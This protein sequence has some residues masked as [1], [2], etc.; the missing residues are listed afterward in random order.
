MNRWIPILVLSLAAA[1]AA[2]AGEIEPA[3]DRQLELL[4]PDGTATALVLLEQQAPVEELSRDLTR[5]GAS[6]AERHETIVR[7]LRD[8]AAMQD[9]LI[10]HLDDGLRS[11]AVEGY[12]SYWIVN[13]V[14][15]RAT[16]AFLRDLALRS[17]VASVGTNPVAEL[18]EPV[19]M[20]DTFGAPRGIG[21][22]RGQQA[23]R[24]DSV[25]YQL[26]I[27]GRGRVLAN[28]DTGVD[29]THPA[30][31]A[32]WRGAN[33]HPYH[34]CWLDVIGDGDT[35]FPEDT[36]SHGTHVMGTITGLG[37]ETGDT[38]GVAWGAQWIAC[39]AIGQGAND[40]FDSDIITA[41]Q[42]LADPDGD[43]ATVDDVPDVVQ[44]SWRVNEDFPGYEDCDPRWWDAIDHCEAGGCVVI[45]SAG[46][47]GPAPMTIGSPPDRTTTPL[48]CF[49]V[50]AVDATNYDWPY[51]IAGFSSRGPSGCE[52]NEMKPEAVAP[53]VDVY[54]S[55]PGG[56]YNGNFSGTSMAGPHVSGIVGLMREANPDLEVDT[57]K[58]ILIDTARD[59]G[60][61]G[62]DNDYGWGLVD[63]L[64][65]VRIAIEGT[66]VLEGTVTNLTDGGAP[67]E[68]AV[69]GLE[70][71]A[72][73]YP[74]DETGAYFGRALAGDYTA[75]AR[76]PSFTE[77]EAA[78]TITVDG[79]TVQDFTLE[80]IA[81]PEVSAVSDPGTI[82]GEAGPYEIEATITDFST[83]DEAQVIYRVS[84]G[85]WL[86]VPM[87]PTGEDR[88]VGG[89][90]GQEA[91]HTIDFYV[92]AI[93]VGDNVGRFPVD[94][95]DSY[96]TFWVTLPT[97][98]DDMESDQG[99]ISGWPGDTASEG[100]WVRVDPVET[101]VG[102]RRGQ[103]EDDHTEDPGHLCFVTGNGEPGEPAGAHDVDDGCTSLVSPTL[104]FSVAQEAFLYYWRW[105][106][107]FGLP[108]DSFQ[109]QISN[110]NGLSWTDIE[111]LEEMA[112][113]WQPAFFLLGDLLEFTSTMRLRFV[114][115]DIDYDGT[116]EGLVDD[117]S[118]EILPPNPTA[119]EETPAAGRPTLLTARP[120]PARSATRIAFQL[121]SPADVTLDL[122]DA[123]GRRVRRLVDNGMAAGPQE[124]TW[125][126]RDDAGR[127]VGAGV[128]FYKLRAGDT[129]R[130]SRVSLVD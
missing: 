62:E 26:G 32:R 122:Y 70:G 97:L 127:R 82:P 81:G 119:V 14:V 41:F 77:Q 51:P 58:Q 6:R 46:N 30:L 48:N 55:V 107:Q 17:D 116:I 73:H 29:G 45:F 130:S 120:N 108:G 8:A 89:I 117:L 93:D 16:A 68:G 83:I 10:A 95:P 112:N 7:A 110:D 35:T 115:C 86:S 49:A 103:P 100:F 23:I 24:A 1:P 20:G 80:D 28:I 101:W 121:A 21:V 75:V 43:P 22:T 2:M 4:P 65:A 44:N 91:G 31:A 109:V 72:A 74:T 98:V 61:P 123:S 71:S 92:E 129:V 60:D 54:S 63:A 42:W 5:R 53:G 18:I 94:A 114:V 19:G 111:V 38:V 50:G 88:Y 85:E 67:L 84:G 124:I 118:L 106:G 64:A 13:G 90:P 66:G 25:W 15:V 125:D 113:E 104:D 36:G 79:V 37:A 96:R 52:G 3:L 34:E 40:D 105:F 47:E 87:T 128:Y 69:I 11:G 78:V 102:G 33:G 39:N 9:P 59:E 27:T 99:W 12:T 76:H 57:I 126:G 56:G